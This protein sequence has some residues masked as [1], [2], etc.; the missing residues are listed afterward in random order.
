MD[1]RTTD[2]T[3]ET[4]LELT[5]VTV[6]YGEQTVLSGLDWSVG[7]G[8]VISALLGPSGCGKSTLLRAVAGLEPLAAG[9][10]ACRGR[11][12]SRVPVHKRDFGLVFQDGQL[13]SGKTVAA[14]IGY[15]LRL[16]RWPRAA[17]AA[18]VD[19][20][21]E[22]IQL[23]GAGKR[24]VT[25]LSGGQ[26]QRVALARALAPRPRLLLLDEPLAALDRRLRDEL[27]V[28]IAEIVR[29]SGTPA[30][31]VTHDHTEAALMADE[32]SIMRAGA[33]VQR[34]VPER[35]WRRPADDWTAEF[36]GA[37][38]LIDGE[39]SGGLLRTGYG[40]VPAGWIDGD[41]GSLRLALRPES[42]V[43]QLD[44]AG[45]GLVT[46]AAA[47]PTGWRLQVR[48]GDR[49]VEAVTARDL[50]VGDRVALTPD[51]ERIAVVGR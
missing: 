23:P 13:F 12:L 33:I 48:I 16:R 43:A 9:T 35:L 20:L 10:V 7:S 45:D 3:G 26:A 38:E 24:R 40:T 34:D 17:I 19:E 31:L 18:R 4:M 21:L 47:L 5:G 46:H 6:R 30:V 8:A 36:L 2:E 42:L 39:L 27:A 44:P 29:A 37:A 49:T 1:E 14:N 32:V 11:D 22:V 41:D 51:P 28:A 15:G 50:A 25:E